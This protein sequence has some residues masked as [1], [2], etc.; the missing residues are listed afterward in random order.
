MN[1]E[2]LMEIINRLVAESV[3]R[4]IAEHDLELL[5]EQHKE[6][7]DSFATLELENAKLKDEC[8]RNSDTISYQYEW[9]LKLEDKNK[10][11]ENRIKELESECSGL[12][13][14]VEK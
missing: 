3:K 7:Q 9:R 2:E 5:A 1:N 13:G 12:A 6:L 8:K 4:A 10:E 11:L 14:E